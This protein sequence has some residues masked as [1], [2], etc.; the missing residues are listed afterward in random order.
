MPDDPTLR[1][2]LNWHLQLLTVRF[3]REMA[4]RQSQ[5]VRKIHAVIIRNVHQVRQN[6]DQHFVIRPVRIID[7]Q[8]PKEVLDL[9]FIFHWSI[10]NACRDRPRQ[11]CFSHFKMDSRRTAAASSVSPFS[12]STFVLD[13]VRTR[14][15][16]NPSRKKNAIAVRALGRRG[17]SPPPNAWG[18]PKSGFRLAR[19]G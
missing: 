10:D 19:F 6:V 7:G 2:F 11:A 14:H 5:R 8:F 4:I 18:L 9:V 17:N 3:H 15:R 13:T 1:L 12:E 16:A